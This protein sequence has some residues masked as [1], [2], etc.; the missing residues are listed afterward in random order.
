MPI[1]IVKENKLLTKKFLLFTKIEDKETLSRFL[2]DFESSSF[3]RQLGIWIRFLEEMNVGIH[4]YQNGYDI[5]ILNN[6]KLDEQ[7]KEHFLF[8]KIGDTFFDFL[9]FCNL[10]IIN[11]L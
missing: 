2:V 11:E 4:S 10:L 1:Q 9:I 6:D 8:D 5:Y 7:Y 3:S